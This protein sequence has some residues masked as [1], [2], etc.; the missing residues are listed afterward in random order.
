MPTRDVSIA[1]AGFAGLAA[2]ILLARAGHRLRV[3]ERFATPQSLGAGILIQP[4]GLAALSV[5]GIETEVLA[6]GA[7][8]TSLLGVTPTGRRVVDLR[9]ADW[10][11]GAFGLGLHRGVLFEA[12]WQAAAAAGVTVV[13]GSP[14]TDLA[15]LQGDADLVVLADGAHSTLRAQTGLPIRHRDYPWGALW[16]VVPDPDETFTRAGVLRQWYRR[17]STMLGVMPTGQRPG[18]GVPVVSLFWSLRADCHEAC[19]AAGLDAWKAAVRELTHDADAVL[20]RITDDAQLTWAHYADVSMPRYHAGKVVVIGDA[21]HAT[22]PQ[23]GQGTNMALLDAVTLA[24]CLAEQADVPRALAFY[25]AERRSHLG[26]YGAASRLLTPL[27]QS[28]QAML[29]WLRDV[30]MAPA[31]RWPIAGSANLETLVGVRGGWLKGEDVRWMAR[32]P[33]HTA[34]KP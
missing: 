29:P 19:R 9:Y 7:R 17:A 31:S 33:L 16:A 27:F 11:T 32:G 30:F 34:G 8:V 14:A 28:D 20:E 23:L 2:A 24:R 22:S 21:A 6:R 10:R 13:T 3:F 5:L 15:H 4:T 12:L 26:Y 18:D 25:S 1:G